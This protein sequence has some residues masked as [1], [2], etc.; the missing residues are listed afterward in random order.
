MAYKGATATGNFTTAGTWHRGSATMVKVDGATSTAV[1]TSNLDSAPYTTMT[2]EVDGVYLNMS[3][4][5]GTT[6]TLTVILYNFTDSTAVKTVTVNQADLP[7]MGNTAVS[8]GSWPFFEFD[9]PVTLN[10]LK[11]YKI[12]LT[13]STTTQCYFYAGA[14]N[15]WNLI[16][17][18]TTAS[19]AAATDRLLISKR[20]TG[21]GV[22]T[23][24]TVTM[25][26]ADTTSFGPCDITQAE[27]A[28]ATGANTQFRLAGN[29]LVWAGGTYT[30]V[31]TNAARTAILEFDN[32]SAGQYGLKGHI[33]STITITGANKVK[34]W[35][36]LAA[37][38]APSATSLT[39]A[40]SVGSAWA[41]GDVCV[42]TSTTLTA[43]D[44]ETKALSAAGSGTTLTI[45]AITN[46]HGG[47]ATTMVQ[48]EVGNLT[49]NVKVRAVTAA[50]TFYFYAATT[51]TASLT[52]VEMIDIYHSTYQGLYF[53]T[54]TGTA[55][56]EN[57]AIYNS[58]TPVAN[59]VGV[60]LAGNTGRCTINQNVIYN[61]DLYQIRQTATTL[62]TN[63]ISNNLCAK[64]TSA[65]SGID[66]IFLQ[67]VGITVT[68]NYCSSGSSN[69]DGALIG[70]KEAAAIGTFSGN[71]VHSAGGGFG[72]GSNTSGSFPS[73]GTVLNCR[74][75]RNGYGV[76]PPPSNAVVERDL[77]ISGLTA[78]G[79]LSAGVWAGN[80]NVMSAGTITFNACTFDAGTTLTQ[81]IGVSVS[82]SVWEKLKFID[83]NL[84]VNQAHA[85]ADIAVASGSS[86]NIQMYNTVLAST[87]VSGQANLHT[88]HSIK[89]SKHDGAA[90]NYRAWYKYGTILRNTT[91]F[92][93][94]TPSMEM[95]PNNASNRL[96]SEPFY[97]NCKNT[98]AP[99]VS[100]Y[101]KKNAAY[102]GSQPR[103]VCKANPSA[104]AAY[105]SD[106]VVATYASAVGSWNQISGSLG[107]VTGNIT[108]KFVVDCDSG[109]SI[110][111]DDFSASVV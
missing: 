60:Y 62:T 3:R 93:T 83:C 17:R 59:S 50:N 79:N 99:T 57:C 76:Y 53:D 54:T 74:S 71:V 19:A 10:V 41:N 16:L 66:N 9:A 38:A 40:D 94:A 89:S 46:A 109:S 107:A 7:A 78:F 4:Q 105:A 106:Q 81:P 68:G 87:E 65:G 95:Q 6:G 55:L 75:W 22:G 32:A 61:T 29:C 45:A 14:S 92:N 1:T 72:F 18:T 85:T 37:D 31:Q 20:L 69:G 82:G 44:V 110:Y 104:G 26:N 35:S 102:A 2:D 64:V 86:A 73:S 67:D 21:A 103:L 56:V 77:L 96:E 47:N 98:E 97:V 42:L 24:V 11:S 51:A 12:R 5:A 23:A 101:I 84:G 80:F 63:V 91:E 90:S 30:Q 43:A 52:W 58:G 48:G 34:S 33:G 13:A 88:N 111:C 49:R 36:L 15:D 28:H 8:P 108:L 25:N 27:L 100:V 39:I 70:L